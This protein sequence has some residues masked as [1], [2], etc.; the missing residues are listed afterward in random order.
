VCPET[1]PWSLQRH[2]PI[3]ADIAHSIVGLKGASQVKRG[4]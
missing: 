1:I 2:V 4:R 3:G